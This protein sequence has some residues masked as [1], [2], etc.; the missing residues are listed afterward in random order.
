M[1]PLDYLTS[2]VTTPRDDA[3]TP[4]AQGAEYS[5]LTAAIEASSQRAL[6]AVAALAGEVSA[7]QARLE[8]MVAQLLSESRNII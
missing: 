2:P 3:G 5:Q 1:R 7:R 6:D 8:Q 4:A